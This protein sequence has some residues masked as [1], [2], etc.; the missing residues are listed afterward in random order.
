MSSE[1]PQIYTLI[2]SGKMAINS[3]PE[4]AII[5]LGVRVP[6]AG[7]YT[8]HWDSQIVE[9]TVQLLDKA[10]GAPIDMLAN[11]SYTFT[12][13]TGGEINDRFSIA[14]APATITGLIDTGNTNQI[15]IS[16][17]QKTVV[18]DGLTGSSA[19]R[20][21]DLPGRNIHAGFTQ[22]GTYQIP[23]SAKGIYVVEVKNEQSSV[24]TKII[25]Q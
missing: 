1:T 12:T 8:I 24:K 15:R 23:L 18:L 16:S 22:G 3:I 6:Q 10:T 13:D 4:E 7:E 11:L 5:D 14:F 9:K 19:I 2:N 25:C 21:Y 17:R 20:L